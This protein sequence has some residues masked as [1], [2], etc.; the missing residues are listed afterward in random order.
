MEGRLGGQRLEQV[1]ELAARGPQE[2]PIRRDPHRDLGNSERHDFR[3]R[4]LTPPV[5]AGLGQEIVSRAIN[6]NAETVEVGVHR[7]LPGRR[8]RVDTADFDLP[9]TTPHTAA[10]VESIIYLY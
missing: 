9:A 4:E 2:S 10:A 8:C 7:G 1:T 3:V 6:S 5:V